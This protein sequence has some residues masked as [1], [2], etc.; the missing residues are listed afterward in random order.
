MRQKNLQ[1]NDSSCRFLLSA[2]GVLLPGLKNQEI[3]PSPMG[4]GD[5]R[6]RWVRSNKAYR[7]MA[8]HQIFSLIYHATGL[9][10]MQS[11]SFQLL[12]NMFS[13]AGIKPFMNPDFCC[14]KTSSMLSITSGILFATNNFNSF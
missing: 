3:L 13:I 6:R 2:A 10:Y 12:L 1:E 11:F 4:R 5:R 8:A 7:D 14:I 9:L